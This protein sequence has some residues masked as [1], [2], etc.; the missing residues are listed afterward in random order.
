MVVDFCRIFGGFLTDFW[1][2]FG[3]GTD[4]SENE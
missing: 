3:A 2:I 4:L 1:R